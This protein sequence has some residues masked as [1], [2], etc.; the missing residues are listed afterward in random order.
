MIINRFADRMFLEILPPTGGVSDF[1]TK[2]H[3]PLPRE[4][5]VYN[6]GE[7]VHVIWVYQLND[8]AGTTTFGLRWYV[9]TDQIQTYHE[10]SPCKAAKWI[11]EFQKV[12]GKGPWISDGDTTLPENLLRHLW[13]R[14]QAKY[15]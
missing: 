15:S 1:L 6:H 5:K 10:G 9:D 2:T 3:F 4:F 12:Q 7:N 8:W 14:V 11:S 13:D